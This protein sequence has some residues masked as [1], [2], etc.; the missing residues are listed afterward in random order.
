MSDWEIF[1][2]KIFLCLIFLT[3]FYQ[4]ST[5]CLVI[6]VFYNFQINISNDF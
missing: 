3:I 4:Y 1:K 5:K 6:S 2:L